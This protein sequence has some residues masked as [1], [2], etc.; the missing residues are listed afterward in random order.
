MVIHV[1][2]SLLYQSASCGSYR[3]VSVVMI[4]TFKYENEVEN[5]G[6][7]VMREVLVISIRF[8]SEQHVE[9]IT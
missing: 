5:V 8:R 7:D 9:N 1:A 6:G 2:L 3:T 4:L